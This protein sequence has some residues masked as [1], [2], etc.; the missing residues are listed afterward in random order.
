MSGDS[1]IFLLDTNIVSD[2]MRNE[3][4]WAA[5]R[6]REAIEAQRVRLLCTS[7]V[8]QCELLFGLAKRPSARLRAAYEVEMSKLEVFNVD[9]TVAPAYANMRAQLERQ[10]TSIG[11]NDALIAA[12]AIAL[13]ATLVSADEAFLQVPGLRVE[14][15]LREAA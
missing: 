5:Q 13:E 8:V 6:A 1:G 9:Q 11:A 2:L 15:W 4:G 3:R 10:G 14:N 12:H 7:I